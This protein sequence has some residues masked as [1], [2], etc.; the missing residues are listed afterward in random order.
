MVSDLIWREWEKRA[1][2]GEYGEWEMGQQW[3]EGESWR[4]REVQKERTRELQHNT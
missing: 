4:V 1:R 2:V 3:K